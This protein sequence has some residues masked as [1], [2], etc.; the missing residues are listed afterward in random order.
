MPANKYALIRY[1]VIDECLT[2]KY[3]PFPTKEELRRACEDALYGSQNQRVSISTIEK[4]LFAMRNDVALGYEAPIEFHKS[5]KGYYYSEEGYTI[6]KVPLGEED[7]EALRFA[8]QTLYQFRDIPA[9]QSFRQLI[10]KIREHVSLSQDE[11]DSGYLDHMLFDESHKSIGDR[12]IP[13]ILK[14]IREHSV[15]SFKYSFHNPSK[16]QKEYFLEPLLLKQFRLGWY[17]IGKDRREDRIKTFGLDRMSDLEIQEEYFAPPA[18]NAKEY[19]KDTFGISHH[20]K[21]IQKVELAVSS[22]IANYLLSAPWHPSMT[23][24]GFDGKDHIISLDLVVNMDLVN[25]IMTWLPDVKVLAPKELREE[26]IK[27]CERAIYIN[28]LTT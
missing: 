24:I 11:F 5:E 7:I 20:N 26:V 9:F 10:S 2:N 1:R 14:S 23:R 28:S 4:D 13:D 25:E 27:R 15:L 21:D 6:K 18:F 16:P 17:V 12:N 19:F 3:R 22:S 8:S